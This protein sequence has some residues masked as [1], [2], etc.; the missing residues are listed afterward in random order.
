MPRRKARRKIL[1]PP[2]FSGYKPYG[3]YEQESGHVELLYEE[4]EAIKLA[5]YYLKPHHEACQ[6]MGISRATFARIYESARR[7]IAQALVET[8]EIKS[9]MGNVYLDRDWFLCNSCYARFPLVKKRNQEY[10]PECSSGD[11]EPIG[12]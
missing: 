5:D 3:S 7:K 10:C 9:S 11:L 2:K 12:N 4:Y 8:K 6:V 1:E